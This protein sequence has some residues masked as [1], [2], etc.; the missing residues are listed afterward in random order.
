MG[1]FL[2]ILGFILFIGLPT[3]LRNSP[4]LLSSVSGTSILSMVFIILIAIGVF[5]IIIT[6]V[7]ASRTNFALAKAKARGK[8]FEIS[9]NQDGDRVTIEK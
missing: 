3:L 5:V 6:A 2:I 4:S 7:G 8:K 1:Y 9:S